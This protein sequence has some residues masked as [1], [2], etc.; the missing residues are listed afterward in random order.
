MKTNHWLN[1]SA[2]VGPQRRVSDG[3]GCRKTAQQLRPRDALGQEVARRPSAVGVADDGPLYV[4][5]DQKE[6]ASKKA[7]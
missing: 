6:K 3:V 5:P 1:R 7:V 4:G 2:N